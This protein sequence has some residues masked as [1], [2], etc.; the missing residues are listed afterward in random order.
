[1]F[2]KNYVEA[3]LKTEQ[4]PVQLPR[5]FI[6]TTTTLLP[7]CDLFPTKMSSSFTRLRIYAVALEYR[8]YALAPLVQHLHAAYLSWHGMQDESMATT[9]TSKKMRLAACR[10]GCVYLG[11]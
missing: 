4:V 1:M 11:G 7:T 9:R 2:L 6:Y 10:G 3:I 8:N 5:R